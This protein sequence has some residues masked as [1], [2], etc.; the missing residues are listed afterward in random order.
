TVTIGQQQGLTASVSPKN[1]TDQSITWSSA[2]ESIARVDQNGMVSAVGVGRTSVY[3]T[4]SN[5]RNCRIYVTVKP[6]YVTSI[7]L[8]SDRSELVSGVAGKNT[9]QLTAA[10]S[11]ADATIKTVTWYSSNRNIATVDQNGFVTAVNPGTVAIYATAQDGSYR[12]TLYRV[13]V[14]SNRFVRNSAIVNKGEFTI[15][16][17]QLNY[18]RD[19]LRVTLYYANYT[20][21]TVTYP[22][23]GVLTLILPDGKLLPV[24]ALDVGRY[25]LRTGCITTYTL[26]LPLK[27]YPQLAGLDLAFCDATVTDGH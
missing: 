1:A 27:N 23:G 12:Q 16:A 2:D 15:S 4:A 22:T 6:V 24:T 13:T 21:K 20:G 9:L 7:A 25:S 26:Y 3:A 14:K 17:K 8:S 11:P 19:H 18:E 10:I 5:G